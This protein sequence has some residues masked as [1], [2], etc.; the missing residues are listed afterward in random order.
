MTFVDLFLFAVF[1]IRSLSGYEDGWKGRP[2]WVSWWQGHI[3]TMGRRD[4]I[5]LFL[6]LY[7]NPWFI[8][9]HVPIHYLLHES[10]YALGVTDKWN[11]ERNAFWGNAASIVLVSSIMTVVAPL[12]W[13]AG[14][15]FGLGVAI[16]SFHKAHEHYVINV[17]EKW[18]RLLRPVGSILRLYF[19]LTRGLFNEC[20]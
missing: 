11:K 14:I 17:V 9:L 8:L 5:I 2:S 7:I 18:E 16:V 19:K 10:F 15:V 13:W 1:L 4:L 20:L 12:Y 6:Y 3:S